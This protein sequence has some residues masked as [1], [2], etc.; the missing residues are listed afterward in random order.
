MSS[1]RVPNAATRL[2]R[3]RSRLIAVLL[4]ALVALAASGVQSAAAVVLR[5]TLNDNWRG[6]YDILVTAP[7]DAGTPGMLAPNQLANGETL[8]LDDLEKIRA[9]DDVEVAA[10]IGEV[11]VPGLATS[12]PK[13]TLPLDAIDT[14][15][16]P[17]AYRLTETYWT[18]DGLGRRLAATQQTRIVVDPVTRAPEPAT[19]GASCIYNDLE[20]DP[21]KYPLLYDRCTI[22]ASSGLVNADLN[23][24]GWSY[25]TDS[26][27]VDGVVGFTF[28]G[29]MF[30]V[31]RVTLVDPEAERALLGDSGAFLDAL[32][33]VAP[34]A[35]T[36]DEEMNAW[37][38]DSSTPYAKDF[39]EFKQAEEVSQGG[40][41]SGAELEEARRMY[42]DAG[43]DFD[44]E[45]E[46]FE[47][48]YTPLLISS[49]GTAPLELD[50][51]VESYGP[52][53]YTNNE[54]GFPYEV[55]AAL[56]AGKVGDE[57]KFLTVDASGLL[58][59]FV[60]A[61]QTV[62]WPGTAQQESTGRAASRSLYFNYLG[63]IT[64]INQTLGKNHEASLDPL[65]FRSAIPS[66]FSDQFLLD[67]VG[68]KAG[69]ESAYSTVKLFTPW[70]NPIAAVPV[71]TFDTSEVLALQ[72]ELSTVPLGAY[73]A[74]G[75]TLEDGSEVG[76]TTTGLGLVGPRTVAIASINS[77]GAW[78][79]DSPINAVRVRVSGLGDFSAAAQQRVV[80]VA[81]GIQTLGYSATIVAGSS[82]TDVAV[83]VEDYAFG[84]TDPAAEQKV[85]P[86]GTVVQ[87]WSELGAA[88]RANTSISTS[89][90]LVLGIA[91]GSTALLLGAVQFASVPRRRAQSAVL[92]ELGWTGGGIR[93]WMAA[94][95][96]PGALVVLLAGIAAAVLSGF[97]NIA[98][99]IAGG[100]VAALLV[101]S[102]VAVVAGSRT[103]TS[104]VSTRLLA[105]RPASRVRGRTVGSFG[106]RQSVIHGVTTGT[107]AI[108]LLV[109]GVS[110]AALT[111]VILDGRRGAGESVIAR[112]LSDQAMIS[113]F[114]LGG[115]ALA[116]GVILA[117]IARRIALARRGPQ[118]EIMRAIGWTTTELRH[119]QRVETTAAAVPAVLLAGAATAAAAWFLYPADVIPLTAVAT[120]SALLSA[121]AV[122]LVRRKATPS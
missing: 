39:L 23:N 121:I 25:S 63:E 67:P 83:N 58:N 31:T 107:Q 102:A 119:A 93:R 61:P 11:A 84:V 100:G 14:A 17:Q 9:V 18:D 112:F 53:R 33:D 77:A 97:S 66:N 116:A 64:P 27:I 98:L 86:L 118:W 74:I 108:A 47:F 41:S 110:S 81:E 2:V 117:V 10:P 24:G 12:A 88:S 20:V 115:T 6:A 71:G 37:A 15:A 44:D 7:S 113:L 78:G 52:A 13:Y 21:E 57:E 70:E 94:E 60:D 65:G 22:H 114:A 1:A 111:L 91:L 85:G 46:K 5:D 90:F 28:G 92:R 89:S 62:P 54:A 40:F 95:E 45:L 19:P 101:T 72:S 38:A 87:Q 35:D 104:K 105:R 109:I 4:L 48:A 36:G 51:T 82:P 30:P 16:G 76:P 103:A 42:A 8:S 26:D 73:E 122:T 59:P 50:V 34:R 49:G 43:R 68:T 56:R 32:I 69:S 80:T 29:S 106:A 75:S 96:V 120:G 55:P 3:E 99:T 79:Q